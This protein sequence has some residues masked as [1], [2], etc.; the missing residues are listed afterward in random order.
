M[1]RYVSWLL[2]VLLLAYLTPPIA[3]AQQPPGP[4]SVSVDAANM[5]NFPQVG[6]TLSVRDANGMTVP[7]LGPDAFE[8]IE[9][10]IPQARP[11]VSAEPLINRALPVHVVLLVDV[12]GSMKGQP[13]MDARAA[14]RTFIE[15][16]GDSDEVALIAFKV[17]IVPDEVDPR[18]EQLPTTDHAAMLTLVDG[19]RARGG[20]PLYDAFY[21][22]V[23]WAQN[24]APSNRA[25][26]LF[27]D[28]VDED[29]GSTIAPDVPIDEAA[30]ANIPV[31]AIGF[32]GVGGRLA[33][34]Y[35]QRAA[36]ATGGTY[37]ETP[38]SAQL[39]HLFRDVLERPKQ[40]YR[41]TYGS[42][43]LP[44]GQM[45]RLQVRV[46][47]GDA[48]GEYDGTFGPT[49]FIPTPTPTPTNTSTP[50]V[51]PTMTATPTPTLTPTATP[52]DTPTPTATATSTPLPTAT[53]VPT[54][55]STPL[56]T[57][58]PVPTATSMPLPAAT[59]APSKTSTPLLT[60]TAVPTKT[61]TPLPTATPVPTKT[62]TPPPTATPVPTK[63][64]TPPPT[65]TPVP[66]KTL[67]PP[68]SATPVPTSTP[69]RLPTATSVPTGTS[70]PVPTAT[71]APTLA[72]TA[73][74]TPT[75]TGASAPAPT[76][77]PAS[78][79]APPATAPSQGWIVPTIVGVVALA[80]IA[81]VVA[82]SRRRG[83]R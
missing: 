77:A 66:T 60:A 6:L 12:S 44:D 81:A 27:T 80:V 26:I 40:Q 52:T 68:P 59:P 19:L 11:V 13:V 43:L 53:P 17:V 61:L 39:I 67:T 38:D 1:A 74:L 32:Q 28:G 78:A 54:H 15:Q 23:L 29:P 35:L 33:R 58:T 82:L 62:L 30:T 51:T 8:I 9:D 69:T 46:K 73:A 76:V 34:E 56:P 72:P 41:L 22:A 10:G 50:T 49:P 31:F 4:L 42:G 7:D 21:K 20:T 71:P 47:A 64:L 25:I 55:T 83:Q 2:L 45:H 37:Q 5:A 65:A 63:T 36:S 16:M 57:A 70:T 24:M 14:A 75:P 48:S 3:H 18:L 79:A